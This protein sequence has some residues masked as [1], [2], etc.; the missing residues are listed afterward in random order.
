MFAELFTQAKKIE[1]YQTAPLA[2]ERLKHLRHLRDTGVSVLTLK[3]VASHQLT[4]VFLLNL[5]D[6][7]KVSSSE[8][9]AAAAEWARTGL[10]GHFEPKSLEATELF[11]SH[12]FQWLRFAGRLDDVVE[13]AHGYTDRVAALA[14]WMR[15][16][17]G[18][19]EAWIKECRRGAD[20]FLQWLEVSKIPLD[21]VTIIDIERYFQEET[22][23]QNY[24]RRTMRSYTHRLSTFLRFAEHRKWCTKGLAL[25]IKPGRVYFDERLPARMSREDVLRILATTESDD[26]L[27]KRDRAILM[28][29]IAY[30]VRTGEVCILRLDDVNWEKET[31]RVR[32]PKSGITQ[33]FPLSASVGRAILRYILEVRPNCSDR[34]LFLKFKA[35]IAPLTGT[36]LA[37]VVRRRAARL[38]IATELR[39]PHALRHAA[40][41]RLL[42]HGMSFKVIGDYLG[43]RD[44]SS[45]AAYAKVDMNVLREV[46]NFSSEVLS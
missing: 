32:R 2:E 27:D 46:A 4:A 34:T 25:G 44:P 12:V 36:G 33:E 19:S 23:Q 5:K 28:I 20:K 10:N 8:V 14:E 29:L 45:T 41:Q 37:G 21:S 42:D 24:S 1:T 35:P 11:R 15:S 30:G 38:G 18:L 16:E 22:A 40:A 39:G 9:D 6:R 31:L 13:S 26:P 43:H 17:R 3:R 7:Q